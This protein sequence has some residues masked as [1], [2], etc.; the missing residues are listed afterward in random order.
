LFPASLKPQP[1]IPGHPPPTASEGSSSTTIRVPGQ[2]STAS[3]FLG[4]SPSGEKTAA[5]LPL[6]MEEALNRALKYNLGLVLG[7]QDTRSARGARL[8]ALSDLLPHLTTRTSES[9]E[10]INLAAFGFP[11]TPTIPA[12]VGPFSVFDTRATL[13]QPIFDLHASNNT[14]AGSASLGA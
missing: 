3:P 12:V 11:A 10:Q 1:G 7:D 9:I 13:G 6:S 5:I 14:R 4:S 2:T 8:R